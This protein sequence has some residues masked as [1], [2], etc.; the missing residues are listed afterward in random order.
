MTLPTLHTTHTLRVWVEGEMRVFEVE[1][2]ANL[3]RTLLA[4]GISP[5]T[6]ITQNLN[7]NGRGICATCGVHFD[8]G[9]PEPIHWHDKLAARFG[10]PR[11]TCQIRVDRDMTIRILADKVIWGA[12]EPERR[13]PPESS[14]KESA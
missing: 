1:D 13:Y 10:Y 7:C 11:L 12:R 3:R 14:T 6:D 4:N 8:Q 2:G 5:Y 9:E